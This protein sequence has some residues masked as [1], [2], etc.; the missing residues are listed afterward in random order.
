MGH[1]GHMGHAGARGGTQA[2]VPSGALICPQVPLRAPTCPCV[3]HVTK[4]THPISYSAHMY[5]QNSLAKE[6]DEIK[7]MNLFYNTVQHP[8][9]SKPYDPSGASRCPKVPP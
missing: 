2:Q 4:M 7:I 9:S 5:T 6:D 8:E 1:L 3:P